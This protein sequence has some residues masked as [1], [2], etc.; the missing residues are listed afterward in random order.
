M[1]PRDKRRVDSTSGRSCDAGR[2][3]TAM[4]E[5]GHR[6]KEPR[7]VDPAT[8]PRSSVCLRVAA[9]FLGMDAR[10]LKARIERGD[11]PVFVDGKVYRIE[12]QDLISY[13]AAH[14]LAS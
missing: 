14:R 6:R 1:T 2:I 7:I 8:H 9:E 13:Q 4:S 12:L 11:L 3:T 5:R 10:T